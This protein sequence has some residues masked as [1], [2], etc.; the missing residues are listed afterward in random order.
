MLQF[1]AQ[2]EKYGEIVNKG[3]FQVSISLFFFQKNQQNPGNNLKIC[4]TTFLTEF[5]PRQI[6]CHIYTK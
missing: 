6:G 4:A 2:T 1:F 5:L 3:I